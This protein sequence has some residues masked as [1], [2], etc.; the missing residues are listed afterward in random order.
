[1]I[2]P[3]LELVEAA[4]SRW[5]TPFY[6]SAWGPVEAA[7][8]DLRMLNGALP[9][10]HW[11]SFK[12]HPVAPL[13]RSW[14]KS[15]LGVEVVS[16]YEFLAALKE[17]FEPNE[18]IINGVAKNR[19]LPG[20]DVEG[21]RV[22]FDS[23]NEACDLASQARMQS[24][25][26]GIR[27]HVAEEYDPDEPA[28]VGQFGMMKDEVET[29]L[30]VLARK[31]VA[32]ETIHFHLRSNVR[33][34]DSYENAIEEASEIC[35]TARFNPIN[36]DCGGG[37]PVPGERYESTDAP[38]GVFDLHQMKEVLDK[39]SS[40]FP[41]VRNVW[42]ENGR[43]ISARSAVLV[44]RVIDIKSRGDSRYLI[45]DGGR[46]NNALVSDWE[47]HDILI[48]PNRDSPPILTTIAGPTCMAF[49]RLARAYLPQDIQIGDHI[50]WMNAGAY[51]IP[52]ETHFS[53]GLAR[54]IWCNADGEL[55][56]A[57]DAESFDAWWGQWV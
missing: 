56:L 37:F 23:L 43:F 50:I 44:V 26:T 5:D 53:H 10:Q 4:L 31:N 20:V 49:D 11:L 8:N 19:W 48:L 40:A 33:S 46:T 57:R 45:C 24:W 16:H 55:F 12:T 25:R 39:V 41:S 32:V 29:A 1:M 47:K 35:R 6:L 13:V 22:H 21:L 18:I 54:V 34:P 36:L 30:D 7:L 17:G 15:G 14:R 51:H 27:C 38:T 2:Y 3:W 52:W 28:F 42:F 9:V